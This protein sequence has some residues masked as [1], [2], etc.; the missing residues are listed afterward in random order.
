MTT[1]S[2]KPVGM[3]F[4]KYIDYGQQFGMVFA[5][6]ITVLPEEHFDEI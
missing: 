3:Y 6:W 4:F 2:V 5:Q 1:F